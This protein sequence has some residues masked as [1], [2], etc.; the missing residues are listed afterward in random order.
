[1]SDH[2]KWID[3]KEEKLPSLLVELLKDRRTFEVQFNIHADGY[4]KRMF[5]GIPEAFSILIRKALEKG[6][7]ETVSVES[8]QT[9][10][11]LTLNGEVTNYYFIELHGEVVVVER[12]NK[13]PYETL[14]MTLPMN[15]D[16]FSE[17]LAERLNEEYKMKFIENEF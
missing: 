6:I 15:L 14:N 3:T 9:H 12:S 16:E 7:I 2:I 8:K 13:N 4:I 5:M 17:F 10:F 1:M 11:T